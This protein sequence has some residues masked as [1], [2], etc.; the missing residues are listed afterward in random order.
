MP[1]PYR[2]RKIEGL[3]ACQSFKPRGVPRR[4]LKL[5]ELSLDEYEAIRLADYLKMEHSEASEKMGI[6]R[7]T[8]TRLIEKARH[9]I[10]GV[11]VE[12]KE[13]IIT[14]GN[15]DLSKTTY[16]C[17]SCGDHQKYDLN[18]HITD[19]PE[20]GSENLENMMDHFIRKGDAHSK[21]KRRGGCNDPR[22]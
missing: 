20:C 8:F 14:G 22:S 4:N 19:C 3:P 10:A 15:I 6:S 5:E 2:R 11:L 18:Q 7:P 12:G 13:L 1:R 21:H 9:K 16:R 17:R